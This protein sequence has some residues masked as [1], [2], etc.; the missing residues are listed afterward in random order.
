MY[1]RGRIV[2]TKCMA[3]TQSEIPWDSR[4]RGRSGGT[5]RRFASQGMVEAKSKYNSK[6]ERWRSMQTTGSLNNR[7][8]RMCDISV[9]ALELPKIQKFKIQS[10][11]KSMLESRSGIPLAG[12][13][14]TRRSS[15]SRFTGAERKGE[16]K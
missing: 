2:T 3:V 7:A 8:K 6:W 11:P 4:G 13:R 12:L 16:C 5:K 10:W 15:M 14:L 1:R 9:R